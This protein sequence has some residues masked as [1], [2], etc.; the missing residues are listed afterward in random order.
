[1][2]I[3][4]LLTPGS[5]T[6]ALGVPTAATPDA[7]VPGEA[8]SDL[9]VAAM[10]AQVEIPIEGVAPMVPAAPAGVPTVEPPVVPIPAVQAPT[11]QPLAIQAP[12]IS[13]TAVPIAAEPSPEVPVVA[14]HLAEAPLA[15]GFTKKSEANASPIESQTPLVEPPE[16]PPLEE[17]ASRKDANAEAPNAPATE[18]DRPEAKAEEPTEVP[19]TIVAEAAAIPAPQASA[20][21]PTV[22][23][24]P[25]TT[26]EPTTA[27]APVAVGNSPTRETKP[28]VRSKPTPVETKPKATLAQPQPTSGPDAELTPVTKAPSAPVEA[29][30]SDVEGSIVPEV[31]VNLVPHKGDRLPV[32]GT[33]LEHAPDLG[34]VPKVT[35]NAETPVQTLEVEKAPLQK[36]KVESTVAVAA[37]IDVPKATT[38]SAAAEVAETAEA[39]TLAA[40]SEDA[41]PSTSSDAAPNDEQAPKDNPQPVA[42]TT[43]VRTVAT[44]RPE[45]G[46]QRPEVDRHLVVRQVADRIENLVASRP[47]EGVTIH[48]EPRDLGSVTLVVK[49]LA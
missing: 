40:K 33:R 37:S 3:A 20:S 49:G 24:Q 21:L 31:A 35:V 18:Q 42:A 10:V 23:P 38:K 32:Q 25:T 45:A 8:F 5:V 12:A 47:R 7:V 26:P 4:A 16:P 27:P 44:D 13:A 17:E 1:M 19:S 11:N 43:T 22:V 28:G 6:P 41:T 15:S 48:L 30:N 34:V 2:D 14:E 36:A 29:M 46:A 9:L 39:A